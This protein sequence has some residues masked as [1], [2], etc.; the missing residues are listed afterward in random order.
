[1]LVWDVAYFPV[2]LLQI[3]S[4]SIAVFA[5]ASVYVR[6]SNGV[7]GAVLM[8]QT[9]IPCAQ[10]V[11][12]VLGLLG[13]RP[14]R[15]VKL[16]LN[17]WMVDGVVDFPLVP[18]GEY[19]HFTA[20]TGDALTFEDRED[21]V[22]DLSHAC[23]IKGWCCHVFVRFSIAARD[24]RAVVLIA[25]ALDPDCLQDASEALRN[26]REI[27]L[28][29]VCHHTGDRSSVLKWASSSL[30]NNREVVLAALANDDGGHTCL[31]YVSQDLRRDKELVL[32]AMR[33]GGWLEFAP[34]FQNDK[35]VVLESVRS[36]GVSLEFASEACQ[37]DKDIVLVAMQENGY[38]LQFASEALRDDEEIVSAAVRGYADDPSHVLRFASL[39]LQRQ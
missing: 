15:P 39:R 1:M 5:M 8:P 17:G 9:R 25:V 22:R 32:V 4:Y 31:E 33:N 2:C 23:E 28:L 11:S 34:A 3:L 29:A 24:D 27:V 14:S 20:T 12:T 13:S 19:L 30:R 16:L 26:D 10:L 38:G 36:C 35:D 18:H 37:N 7:S 6:V 21:L